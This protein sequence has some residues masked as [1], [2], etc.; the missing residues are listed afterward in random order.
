[1]VLPLAKVQPGPMVSTAPA[2][3]S[4][5]EGS[6]AF[7]MPMTLLVSMVPTGVHGSSGLHGS[8][9]FLGNH[10]FFCYQPS[11]ALFTDL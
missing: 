6:M 1:M 2:A 9:R 7:K 3:P 11:P 4:A 10:G 8:S 5:L